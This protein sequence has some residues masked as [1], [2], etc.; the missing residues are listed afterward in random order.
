MKRS[1]LSRY[2]IV[3]LVFVAHFNTSH[4]KSAFAE[5]SKLVEEAGWREIQFAE[6]KSNQFSICGRHC[7]KVDSRS[8]VSMIRRRLKIDI[9]EKKFFSWKWKVTVPPAPS[10]LANKGEDDRPLAVYIT[11]PFDVRNASIS[12]RAMRSLVELRYGEEAPGRVLS[13]VWASTAQKGEVI[14]SPF[15]GAQHKMIIKRNIGS[16][17]DVWLEEKVNLIA[18]YK[19]SFGAE[20]ERILDILI[21]SDTDDTRSFTTGFVKN[22]RFTSR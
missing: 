15:G 22:M 7:I 17:L 8:G 10:N 4:L 3:G 2:I 1:I 9:A 16:R 19:N 12:E 11:F 13:Y 20:P 14:E 18:D 6:K 21:S 5:V